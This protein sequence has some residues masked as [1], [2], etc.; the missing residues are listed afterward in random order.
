MLSHAAHALREL[1]HHYKPV[2]V[3]FSAAADEPSRQKAYH[4]MMRRLV[5]ENVGNGEYVFLHEPPMQADREWGIYG[6][7]A[8]FHIVHKAAADLPRYEGMERIGAG[9]PV[10][11][12][13]ESG[14]YRVLLAAAPNPDFEDMPGED[15]PLQVSQWAKA[16][17]IGH[18]AQIARAWID[19]HELGA[20]HWYT[21]GGGRVEDANGNHVAQISY[22][23]RIWHPTKE[24]VELFPELSKPHY[25]E[26][27]LMN[28]GAT[29]ADVMAARPI[30][31]RIA[32][33]MNTV[34]MSNDQDWQD[35]QRKSIAPAI[36]A[37]EPARDLQR[38]SPGM[39][40]LMALRARRAAG[41]GEGYVYM[42][43]GQK[44]L[45]EL[46]AR[47]GAAGFAN[48]PPEGGGLGIPGAESQYLRHGP[49]EEGQYGITFK[50]PEGAEQHLGVARMKPIESGDSENPMMHV[51]FHNGS[52]A[53]MRVPNEHRREI[54]GQMIK[55]MP[56]PMTV[57]Q[58]RAQRL[59]TR[60]AS[61]E[62]S[63]AESAKREERASIQQKIRDKQERAGGM[64]SGLTFAMPEIPYVS[65]GGEQHVSPAA[66][67][68][69]TEHFRNNVLP[70]VVTH[71]GRTPE[72]RE[73]LAG[74]MRSHEMGHAIAGSLGRYGEQ[75]VQTDTGDVD[76]RKVQDYVPLVYGLVLKDAEK[77]R[78]GMTETVKDK[79][80][81]E[82]HEKPINFETHVLRS[83][84]RNVTR[85]T[86]RERFDPNAPKETSIYG[87]DDS[88]RPLSDEDIDRGTAARDEMRNNLAN[89]WM[90]AYLD[91]A[92]LDI[93]QERAKDPSLKRLRSR[94]GD[95][96]VD[97]RIK[98]IDQLV[99]MFNLFVESGY[100]M[101]EEA[102]QFMPPPPKTPAKNVTDIKDWLLPHERKF[103]REFTAGMPLNERKLAK[104]I[105][106]AKR[107]GLRVPQDL[108]GHP[109]LPPG[110]NQRSIKSMSG[111]LIRAAAA[112]K[113]ETGTDLLSNLVRQP[114]Y[115]TRRI[116]YVEEPE[117][118]AGLEEFIREKLSQENAPV[119]V[120]K[121][122]TQTML[123]N[124]MANRL[125]DDP[126]L[127]GLARNRRQESIA[128]HGKGVGGSANMNAKAFIMDHLAKFKK[129]IPEYFESIKRP[130]FAQKYRDKDAGIKA[131]HSQSNLARRGMAESVASE[132][133]LKISRNK[134]TETRRKVRQGGLKQ[135][136]DRS[137]LNLQALPPV[138]EAEFGRTGQGRRIAHPKEKADFVM[139][140]IHGRLEHKSVAQILE[141]PD[142]RSLIELPG[143]FR[144]DVD[145][146][147][148]KR[149][150]AIVEHYWKA[151]VMPIL[152]EKSP[153]VA[154]L[155]G[156]HP[157]KLKRLYHPLSQSQEIV[158]PE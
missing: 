67:D 32:E 33:D 31:G 89:Q 125:Y 24:G 130:D 4:H 59:A 21:G 88:E 144:R 77:W 100:Q 136:I 95:E 11:M 141:E 61:D 158:S 109:M 7:P 5:K 142:V 149:L 155:L 153:V 152:R 104:L 45:F 6:K 91:K 3:E 124:V 43:P 132:E 93:F 90:A 55:A 1:V 46:R 86:R 26:N 48:D 54:I 22:N 118:H 150:K 143:F 147:N 63:A 15:R 119:P 49:T 20:G 75:E 53:L 70:A 78:P 51:T 58:K 27:P 65:R 145:I 18:A 107:A 12:A 28:S 148:P 106:V 47:R 123:G 97:E 114:E 92:G 30:G 98:Q 140:I 151:T 94:Y 74:T 34:A 134:D 37:P 108:Y 25:G 154:G 66:N 23:G 157:A 29:M 39:A 76:P 10:A 40:I 120:M 2:S 117:H 41:S 38:V 14:A 122:L 116:P 101:P 83:I 16:K 57:E 36:D 17:S 80:T 85:L 96:A 99:P 42:S 113:K 110:N 87:K 13:N 137:T 9:E 71:H 139:K 131:A 69:I 135:S 129:W 72:L 19:G 126:E 138:L 79:E 52:T 60:S 102:R 111:R 146:D 82:A 156:E 81:G 56:K 44:I 133:R 112:H 68:I 8:Y 128:K 50:T 35:S 105:Y 127:V 64:P 62:V 121:I 73:Q 84:W 103:F 115:K